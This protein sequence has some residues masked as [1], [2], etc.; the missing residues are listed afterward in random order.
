MFTYHWCWQSQILS[1]LHT[2]YCDIA[3]SCLFCIP[4]LFDL[5]MFVLNATLSN[6]SAISW[7]PV[8]VMERAGVPVENHRT[9]ATNWSTSSLA[10]PSRMHPFVKFTK[11]GAN[12]RRIGD[13]LV[14]VA[15]GPCFAYHLLWNSHVLSAEHTIYHEITRSSLF[16]ITFNMT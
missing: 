6:I 10:V 14:W 4:F 2:V 9:W 15:T 1:V 12:P 7:Q 13:R 8:L 5:I 11:P 16:C 3:T